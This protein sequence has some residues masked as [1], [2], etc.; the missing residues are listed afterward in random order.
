MSN[1]QSI[2]FLS[3]PTPARL[4]KEM[5]NIGDSYSHPWDLIAELS[6]NAV[7]AI[8]LHRK[9][10]GEDCRKH[11]IEITINS[12]ERSI[13]IYDTGIGFDFK[14]FAE[15]LAPHGTDKTFSDPIIGQKGVGLTYTIFTSDYYEIETKSVKG[16][17]KG[18]IENATSWKNSIISDM[19][20][21]VYTQYKERNFDPKETFTIILLKDV[22]R[23]YDESEEIFYQSISILQYLLRT[24]TAIGFL[25]GC[26]NNNHKLDVDIKL[27]FV[28][29]SGQ[30]YQEKI[31][32]TYMLPEEFVA[33]NKI[34]NLE[35]FKKTAATLDDR[36]KARKLQGNCLIRVGATNRA[37]RRINYYCFFAPSRGLWEDICKKNDLKI[38]DSSGDEINLYEGGIYIGSRGM[39]TG[40]RLEPPITG[41]AGYWPNFYIIVEDDSIVFDLGR[42]SV[43]GRTKGLLKDIAKNLFNEFLPFVEY[44]RTDPAVRQTVSTVQQ[45][46]KQKIFEE[47]NK[48]PDIG[49]DKI[50]Y[51]KHPDGQ[52]A[53]VVALFHELVSVSILEGYYT[54]KRGYKMT[55]DLWGT[56]KIHKE[57][58]GNNYAHLANESGYIELPTVI[59]FKFKAEDIL[60]DFEDNIKYFT[61]IDLIV[62]WDL[63]ETKFSRQRVKVE[64][65]KTEEVFFYGS[66]YKLIWP[67][68]YNLGTAGEKPVVALRKFIQDF[69]AKR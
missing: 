57:K 51:L 43:P 33:K 45:Y 23:T 69:L 44:V 1:M 37:G 64:L 14:K 11:R 41:Y 10:H 38:T 9:K 28:D 47:L 50:C 66:N 65:L 67:G 20:K 19:P 2:D 46:E 31:E 40:I 30:R 39:P 29:R 59:E 6:Q 56:Y 61:D 52:E 55:Y 34:I 18:H 8:I 36:Q 7:D 42:K 68:A 3:K 17:I 53:G 62:C 54:L 32:P 4:K 58:I 25:K 63:D 16:H 5:Q 48:L 26:F 12:I 27:T 15:L 35:E 60:S 22:E 24:K 13:E 21:F 49:I